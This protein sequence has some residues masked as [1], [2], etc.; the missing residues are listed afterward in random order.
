MRTAAPLSPESSRSALHA[1]LDESLALPPEYDGGLSPHLPMA[2]GETE[3][4]QALVTNDLE[5]AWPG[6]SAPRT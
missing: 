1:L 4:V 6:V 2:L 5:P 3:A